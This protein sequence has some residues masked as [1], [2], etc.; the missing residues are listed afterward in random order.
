MAD[1][2]MRTVNCGCG[3]QRALVVCGHDMVNAM[4]TMSCAKWSENGVWRILYSKG[5]C[6]SQKASVVCAQEFHPT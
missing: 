6:G 5:L 1:Q 4:C 3:F 2:A